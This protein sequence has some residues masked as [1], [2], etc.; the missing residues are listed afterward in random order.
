VSETAVDD[1][2]LERRNR[3][4]LGAA[5]VVGVLCLLGIVALRPIQTFHNFVGRRHPDEP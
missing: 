5:V 1:E 2:T 4:G 3:A